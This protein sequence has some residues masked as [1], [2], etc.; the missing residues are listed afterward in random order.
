MEFDFI[1]QEIAA[2]DGCR[3][4]MPKKKYAEQKGKSISGAK[5]NVI[6]EIYNQLSNL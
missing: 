4:T 6:D 2:K 1:F 5:S 3:Q